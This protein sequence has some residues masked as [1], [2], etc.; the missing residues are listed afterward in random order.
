MKGMIICLGHEYSPED[1]DTETNLLF[2]L[3]VK[4][5]RNPK[6]PPDATDPEILYLNSKGRELLLAT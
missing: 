6:A 1:V 4:C 2:E 5:T 3:K